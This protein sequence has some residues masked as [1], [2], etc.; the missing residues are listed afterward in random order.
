MKWMKK[1]VPANRNGNDYTLCVRLKSFFRVFFFHITRN[2]FF[3]LLLWWWQHK[4]L[5]AFLLRTIS[6]MLLV[7]IYHF[8]ISL[9]FFFLFT[10][11]TAKWINNRTLTPSTKAHTHMHTKERLKKINMNQNNNKSIIFWIIRRPII[12]VYKIA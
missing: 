6:C 4:T 8:V 3:F 7:S 12:P 9:T 10:L 11:A 5:M 1:N 2:S